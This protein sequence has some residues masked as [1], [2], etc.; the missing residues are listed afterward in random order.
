MDERFPH[1]DTPRL[2]AREGEL[3][4]LDKPAGTAVHA[5]G[6]VA[7]EDLIAWARAA[8]G[9]P[10]GLAPIHRLD[11]ETSG[12]VLCSADP[13]LRG[14]LGRWFA[15]GEVDKRYLGLAIGRTR[16]KGAIRRP[17]KD[18]RRR[19]ALRAVTRYRCLEWLG[20]F[21]LLALHPETGRR[22][23]LRRHLHGLGHPLVGDR[24]YRPRRFQ[25]VPGFPGRLWLHAAE[26][27]L[28]DGRRFVAPLAPELEAHLRVL[29]DGLAD[30]SS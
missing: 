9:A 22:H 30:Q 7:G 3:W 20:G 2:V 11:R 24:R 16:R 19:G 4:V 12:L 21:S 27:A 17:L 18:P 10:D 13:A 8:L 1:R 15:D 26:L 25:V 28:P 23:Q 5:A 29:R 14:A 6:E